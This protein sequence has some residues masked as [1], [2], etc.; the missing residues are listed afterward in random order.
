M[1]FVVYSL[2]PCLEMFNLRRRALF[3]ALQIP[4]PSELAFPLSPQM[5][6]AGSVSPDPSD[7]LIYAAALRRGGAAMLDRLGGTGG[8]SMR[9]WRCLL[10]DLRWLSSR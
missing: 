5:S 10:R 4:L 3:S 8:A 1:L 7:L 6:T 2:A 9:G